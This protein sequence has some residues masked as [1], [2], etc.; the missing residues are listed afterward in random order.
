MK[1]QPEIKINLIDL[2]MKEIVYQIRYSKFYKIA[3]LHVVNDCR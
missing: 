3:N 2:L 1:L